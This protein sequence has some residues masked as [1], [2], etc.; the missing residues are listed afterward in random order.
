MPK[1]S[2]YNKVVEA[3]EKLREMFRSVLEEHKSTYQQGIYR[4]FI[5]VY[6]EKINATEDPTSS[7]YKEVGG[8]I[9]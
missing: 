5:D 7:F 3:V 9:K 2:G 6:L 4:D 1:K 8:K